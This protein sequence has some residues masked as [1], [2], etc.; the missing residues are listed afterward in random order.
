M[1]RCARCGN[2]LGTDAHVAS[3]TVSHTSDTYT[4]SYYFCTPC[5]EYTIAICHDRFCDEEEYS[6][7]GPVTK[8]IGD[9]SIALIKRCPDPGN[10]HCHCETHESY[11]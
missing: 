6:V 8:S 4:D 9:E 5:G 2:E 1:V 3:I 10:K 7:R 11:P